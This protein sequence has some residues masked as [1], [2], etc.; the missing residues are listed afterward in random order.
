MYHSEKTLRYQDTIAR[1]QRYA[2]L[3]I[4]ACKISQR[5]VQSLL[6]INFVKNS[7]SCR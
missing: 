1:Q 5:L 6:R 2:L 4:P 7:C 3:A